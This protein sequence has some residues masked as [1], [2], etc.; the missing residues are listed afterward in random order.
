MNILRKIKNN[1]GTEV[2]ETMKKESNGQ[3][4]SGLFKKVTGETPSGTI[5]L[6]SDY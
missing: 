3:S 4:K 6:L 1:Y 2:F 5:C